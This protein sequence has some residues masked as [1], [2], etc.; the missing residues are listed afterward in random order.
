MTKATPS[1]VARGKGKNDKKSTDQD[2]NQNLAEKPA[3]D[4]QNGK[5]NKNQKRKGSAAR[6]QK[7]NAKPTSNKAKPIEQLDP[8]Q[9]IDD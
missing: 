9:S 3:E 4:I 5:A 2:L 7:S 1:N 6:N 8:N